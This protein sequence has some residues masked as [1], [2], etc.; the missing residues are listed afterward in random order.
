MA[1]GKNKRLSKG[2]KKGG[3]KKV[4]DPFA[5]KEWYD[6]RA[7][8][9]FTTRTIGKTLVNRTQGTRIASEGLKGRV[10]EMSLADLNKDEH[11]FRKFR[12]V[13]E[14]VQGK[15]CLTNFHGMSFTRDKLCSMV[16]KWQTLIEAHVDVKT[17]D[18][19]LLRLFCIGFTKRHQNQNAQ[20]KTCY[21]QHT[22]VRAIRAKMI[23]IMSK[24]VSTAE[25]REVVS[26]LI[27]DSIG[28]DIEKACHSIYPLH[29]VYV[30]KVKVLRK[31]KLDLGK[32]MEMHGDSAGAKTTDA[33]GQP[34]DRPEGY[35]PPVQEAV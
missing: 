3:K 26:K 15:H 24:E 25:L 29:D 35:E 33:A 4:V 30:R 19:Y 20:R 27:P 16:K 23:E 17:S 12:L 6:V 11:D 31:P 32:L 10:F 21:A 8:S 22:Q 1:V 5:R 7:P 18:G 28:R 14:D 13:C 2:G 9:M 34:V